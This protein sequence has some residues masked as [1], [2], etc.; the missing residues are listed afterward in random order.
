M[1]CQWVEIDGGANQSSLAL[2]RIDFQGDPSTE[3]EWDDK[4]LED[5]PV[6]GSNVK[7][8][9]AFAKSSEPNS[10]TTQLFINF[11]DNVDLDQ[12]GFAPIGEVIQ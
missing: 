7:G 9:I 5:D 12:M 6:V 10:R 4:T 3:K 8:T 2:A 1:C 11:D